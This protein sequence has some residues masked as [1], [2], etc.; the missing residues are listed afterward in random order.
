M[1]SKIPRASRSSSSFSSRM[2]DESDGG[3]DADRCGWDRPCGARDVGRVRD[4]GS[5]NRKKWTKRLESVVHP[6]VHD[7]HGNPVAQYDAKGRVSANW[8]R[9]QHSHAVRREAATMVLLSFVVV[10][11]RPL[12]VCSCDVQV[13]HVFAVSL[14]ANLIKVVDDLAAMGTGQ[15]KVRSCTNVCASCFD[16]KGADIAGAY[17]FQKGTGT[18]GSKYQCMLLYA[19]DIK[20]VCV[21]VCVC[22]YVA[23]ARVLRCLIDI[24]TIDSRRVLVG[25]IPLLL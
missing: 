4:Y 15:G 13:L 18:G 11:L 1:G 19:Q 23:S 24:V 6:V 12:R 22:V 8:V 10:R 9:L 5:T 25:C 16:S 14:V 7:K 17:S 3:G 2:A 20:C 21:C